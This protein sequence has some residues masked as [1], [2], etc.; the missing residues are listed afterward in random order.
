MH[1]GEGV[2]ILK[3][4]K[5][6]DPLPKQ[7]KLLGSGGKIKLERLIIIKF[8]LPSLNFLLERIQ[9]LSNPNHLVK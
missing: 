4:D 6:V 8:I 2:C 7:L 9:S 5:H 1:K 3:P